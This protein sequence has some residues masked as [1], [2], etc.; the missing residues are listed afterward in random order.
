MKRIAVRP[1]S[2]ALL[3]TALGAKLCFADLRERWRSRASRRCVP[4][5]ELGNKS[6]RGLTAPARRDRCNGRVNYHATTCPGSHHLTPL[7]AELPLDARPVCRHDGVQ[8]GALSRH[9]AGLRATGRIPAVR[10]RGHPRR[11]A[12]APPDRQP[13]PLEPR[14]LPVGRRGLRRGGV[15]LR[16]SPRAAL[17]VAAAAGRT[18]R[19]RRDARIPA[20]DVHL[21]RPVGRGQRPV[22]RGGVRRVPFGPA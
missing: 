16:A 17:P 5:L 13:G 12:L 14:A 2:Q 22:R 15:A 9:A 1:R 11:P 3:G 4:K 18:G 20:P 7:V 10:P 8:P 19:R 21:P 6:N